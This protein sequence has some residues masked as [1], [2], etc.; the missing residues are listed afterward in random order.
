MV[1]D[2]TAKTFLYR[3]RIFDVID[4]SVRDQEELGRPTD[5]FQPLA[6]P[7][8]GIKQNHAFRP[9]DQI[10]IGFEDTT[11]KELKLDHIE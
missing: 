1:S 2:L 8:W 3:M 5:S 9:R 7:R 10:G 4:V 6:S 11:N